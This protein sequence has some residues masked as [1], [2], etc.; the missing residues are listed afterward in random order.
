MVVKVSV[1][2]AH[3]EAA[4]RPGGGE[5][6]CLLLSRLARATNQALA[7][8]LSELGL[9]SQ[10]FAI[11]DLL[12]EDGPAAQTDLAVQLGVHASNLVRLLDEM[13]E[14][15]LLVRRRDPRDR[16]RQLVVPTR[17]GAEILTRAERTAA[18]VEHE[19]LSPLSRSEQRQLRGLLGRLAADRCGRPRGGQAED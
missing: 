11:L 19:L 4:G 7:C 16:R 17:A 10:Q 3:A 1:K 9:R 8:A 13:E 6:C 12:V 15:G 5:D 2:R 18:E 14:R